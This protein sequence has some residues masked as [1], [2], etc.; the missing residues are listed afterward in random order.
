VDQAGSRADGW[1]VLPAASSALACCRN[2]VVTQRVEFGTGSGWG[3]PPRSKIQKGT[4]AS[5][6]PRPGGQ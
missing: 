2:A 5:K 1:P 6:S 4:C 3:R